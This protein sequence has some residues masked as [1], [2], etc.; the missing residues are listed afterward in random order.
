MFEWERALYQVLKAHIVGYD[1]FNSIAP[2]FVNETPPPQYI[3]IGE[4]TCVPAQA[5]RD[6]ADCRVTS[7]LHVF[8]RGQD[9][10]EL[11]SMFDDIA[12]TVSAGF[13]LGEFVLPQYIV[14]GASIEMIEAFLE[15]Y[16]SGETWQHGVIRIAAD[17]QQKE[18]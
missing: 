15:E 11:N 2:I 4:Y 13:D 1:V 8:N 10:Q 14:H 6:V 17:L 7:T 3:N 5:K 16:E 9:K 18:I 12:Q